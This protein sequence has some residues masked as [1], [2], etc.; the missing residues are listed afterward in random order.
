[1]SL[2]EAI[3]TAAAGREVPADL[4][5]A[6]FG[7][8]MD[9]EATPAQ[10]AALLVALRTKGETVAEIV[11]AARA[12][13]ARATTVSARD[14]RT[15][16]NCGT[17]GS[18]LDTFSIS[19]TAAFV[20]AGAGVPVAKHGNRAASRPTGSFDVFEALGVRIDLPIP[21]CGRIL[22]EIG[23]APF[24]AQTAHPA[25]RFA[26][27]VRREIGIRTLMNCMGPLLNPAGVRNQLVGCY[28]A[29][30][31][32]PLAAALGQ[33]GRKRAMVVHG[34]DGLDDLTTTGM[35]RVAFFQQEDG[36]GGKVEVF[37]LDPESCGIPRAPLEDLAGADPTGNA[38]I[39]RVILDGERGPRRDIV[40]L[41]AGACLFIAEAAASIEEGVEQARESIDSGAARAKLD[42]LIEATNRAGA[43]ALA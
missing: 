6:G 36:G 39:T 32:E 18:G 30:L 14:P 19:T 43:E 34:S 29:A 24:F 37:D 35:S 17:G 4:L 20:V 9:G 3:A 12:L 42:A 40:S 27:P 33:L 31:V 38:I 8:I 28:D 26:A 15:I 41:N 22:D 10:I 23:I 7:E 13:S 11:A 5:E 21:A 1:V 16:D 25:M 2:L